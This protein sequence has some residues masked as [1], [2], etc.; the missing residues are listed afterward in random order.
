[1]RDIQD[2]KTGWGEGSRCLMVAAL[3]LSL[4]V[5]AAGCGE[6]EQ[7]PTEPTYEP[8]ELGEIAAADDAHFDAEWTE[9]VIVAEEADVMSGLADLQPYDG[10]FSVD[11]DSPLLDGVEVGSVVM[12]PQVGFFE[13]L[14]MEETGDQV[15]LTTQWAR[16]SDVFEYADMTFE[17][18]IHGEEEGRAFGLGPAPAEGSQEQGLITQPLSL[19]NGPFTLSEDGVAVSG[20]DGG[21]TEVSVGSGGAALK[22]SSNSGGTKANLNARLSNF[23]AQGAIF[24]E[25][26][27]E[28]PDP[29]ILIEFTNLQ[30]DITSSIEISGAAGESEIVPRASLVFPFMI[31]PVPAYVSLGVRVRVQSSISSGDTV[32]AASSGFTLN[33]SVALARNTDGGFGAE[34]QINSFEAHDTELS[35]DSAI[36]AGVGIDVDAPRISFG[37]GRPGIA[38]GSVYGTLSTELVSNATIDAFSG[39]YCGTV[40]ANAAIFVGGEIEAFFW[41]TSQQSQIYHDSVDLMETGDLC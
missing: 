11:A 16:F 3:T 7:G 12:W 27:Q 31:G 15:E 29:S 30:V 33:G 6:D 14:E 23:D 17:H 24:L 8:T 40:G 38:S 35:F 1:M 37:M 22:F 5:F 13:I 9:E 2:M 25:P 21:N 19:T 20:G 36:T 28:D 39:D 18:G 10:V 41:S 4:V 32:M 26:G 34:G